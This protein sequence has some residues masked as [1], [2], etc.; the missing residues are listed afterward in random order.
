MALVLD[1][2]AL[3]AWFQDK[4]AAARIQSF[5]DAAAAGSD[6]LTL[7]VSAINAGEVYYQLIRARRQPQA[8]QFWRSLQGHEM[9]LTLVPAT[10]PRVKRAAA[11]KARYP[12]AYAD[13]FAVALAVEKR[14]RLATGDPEIRRPERDGLISLEW[15]G[16]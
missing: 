14:A 5:L 15:L 4:P 12:L 3:I 13:A 6:P 10:T 11:I 2:W 1:S 7:Y 9:P 8:E 16:R